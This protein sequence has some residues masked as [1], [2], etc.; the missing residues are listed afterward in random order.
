MESVSARDPRA[1]DGV[2]WGEAS[3]DVMILTI[4]C[5]GLDRRKRKEKGQREKPMGFSG[6]FALRSPS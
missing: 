2:L 6:D 3:C 4:L 1:Q 5:L